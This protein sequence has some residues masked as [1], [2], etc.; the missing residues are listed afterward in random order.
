MT[1]QV[2][3]RVEAIVDHIADNETLLKGDTGTIVRVWEGGNTV[4]VCW[5]F[6]IKSGHDCGGYCGR[7]YGWN[8]HTRGIKKSS[9]ES[10]VGGDIEVDTSDLLALFGGVCHV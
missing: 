9:K 1:F 4:S 2:G 3:D 6:P 10:L 8:V 7:G 5:D